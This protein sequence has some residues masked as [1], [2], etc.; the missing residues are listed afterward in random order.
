M[1]IKTRNNNTLSESEYF[2]KIRSALRKC[3]QYWQP[4]LKALEKSSRPSQ[5][6]N[7]RIK[8][9]YQC[10][11]CKKW[12]KRADVQID[13]IIGCGSLRSYED[14]VPFLQRLTIEDPKGFQI[15]CKSCHIKKT[16]ASRSS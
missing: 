12:Y 11:H 16:K 6:E 1:K 3:F 10:N 7:K 8:K 14:I 9:E 5:S 2:S 4:A 13:H 15:L